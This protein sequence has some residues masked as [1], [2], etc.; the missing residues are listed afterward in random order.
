MSVGWEY[1]VEYNYSKA[2]I[3]PVIHMILRDPSRCQGKE[4]LPGQANA[5]R[6]NC[7]KAITLHLLAMPAS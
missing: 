2:Q 6:A 1:P 7:T 5:Y 4:S 3:Y